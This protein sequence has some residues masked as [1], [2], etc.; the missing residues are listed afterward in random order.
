[1]WGDGRLNE[2]IIWS[3]ILNQIKEELSSLSYDTW[4]AETELY[5]LKDGNA[6]IIVPMPIHKKHL[7]DNYH[8]IITNKIS[9]VV[10]DSYEIK[11]RS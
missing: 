4:F 7:M 8:D 1:M 5:R 6:Y 2:K 11:R 10:G 3:N 9:E